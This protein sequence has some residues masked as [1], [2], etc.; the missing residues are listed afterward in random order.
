MRGVP[1]ERPATSGGRLIGQGDVEDLGGSAQDA[2]EL[3]LGVIVE[4]IGHAEPIPQRAGDG[5]NARRGADDGDLLD[6]ESHGSRAGALAEH[7]VERE[8]LHR[9]IQDLLHDMAEP[10]DLVDEQHVALAEAGEH[11]GEVAGALDRRAGGR[12]NLRTHLRRDDVRQRRLAEAR[13]AVQQDVVD[14]LGPMLRS[15]DQ[16]RQVLLDPILAGELVEPSRPNGRLECELLLRDRGA[17]DALD[18]HRSGAKSNM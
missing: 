15:V 6:L 5:A 13:R 18:R 2:L 12:A 9:G 4:P 1:R 10:M 16:D 8:V 14:R 11:G 7:D 3:G 17:R